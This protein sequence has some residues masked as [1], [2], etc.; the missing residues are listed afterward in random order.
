MYLNYPIA[1]SLKL[2]NQCNYKC[3]H[4][5]ANSGN[6][7]DEMTKED[8]FNIIDEI[9]D[10]NAFV[11]DLTG[12]E[13][14]LRK[15]IKEIIEYCDTKSFSLV[16][17]S[18]ASLINE[19]MAYFL[20][21]HKISLVK[22]SLDSA[23][24][25]I[26]NFIRGSENA[27][28]LTIEGIKNLRKFNIPVTIQVAVSK[29]NSKNLE[30]LIQLCEILDINGI[31]FFIVL[32]GGRA[33]NISSEIFKPI[34][35]E[36]FYKEL[37]LLKKK[38]PNIK[39]LHDSPLQCVYEITN[40]IRPLN[41]K[42]T[43]CLAA[44]T[45]VFIKENGDVIPCPYFDYIMGNIK[46]EKLKDIWLKSPIRNKLYN[47]NFLDKECQLCEYIIECFGGC[48]AA[49]YAIYNS[50]KKKDPYCWMVRK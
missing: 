20:A 6:I 11:L 48:R 39:F 50:I 42:E 7:T 45:A 2:T 41:K 46:K 25:K 5:M 19:E 27:F 40:N 14:F 10:N 24:D 31:N 13:C 21:L 47:I 30:E 1:V 26:H 49:S 34:E 33:I 29:I 28:N 37:Y 44:K 15:D 22:V 9:S 43:S 4:C 18:N 35:V 16:V 8:I 17:S 36:K 23:N 12:G 32:P 3:I 38:Y